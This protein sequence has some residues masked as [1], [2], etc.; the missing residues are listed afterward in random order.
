MMVCLKIHAYCCII[1]LNP[2]IKIDEID[3]ESW[4]FNITIHDEGDG[5]TLC[6]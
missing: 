3:E 5:L 1:Y 2:L 6:E 4:Q